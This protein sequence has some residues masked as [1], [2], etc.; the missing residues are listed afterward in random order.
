MSLKSVP[1]L[2]FVGVSS[3]QYRA[4]PDIEFEDSY[5]GDEEIYTYVEFKDLIAECIRY[6]IECTNL[7]ERLPEFDREYSIWDRMLPPEN[8]PASM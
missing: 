4:E 5:N 1:N 2:V 8:I 3:Y 7:T 6:G